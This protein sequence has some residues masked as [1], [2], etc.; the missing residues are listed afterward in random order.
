M[1]R[2]FHAGWRSVDLVAEVAAPGS[3]ARSPWVLKELYQR[4]TGDVPPLTD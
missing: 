2:Q 3:K 4:M 1:R